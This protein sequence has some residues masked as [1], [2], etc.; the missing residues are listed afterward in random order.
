MFSTEEAQAIARAWRSFAETGTPDGEVV[1]PVIKESWKRSR[2]AGLDPFSLNKPSLTQK[3]LDRRLTRRK[4]VIEIAKPFMRLL[5]DFVAGSGFAVVLSDEEGCVLEVVADSDAV[6]NACKES[7]LVTGGVR[8]E[9]FVG[10]NGIGTCLALNEP[11]L[12]W[13]EEHFFIGLHKWTCTGVPIHGES[14]E[15][16][17]CLSMSGPKERVHLHT[18]GM[19]IAAAAAIEK[20]ISLERSTAETLHMNQLLIAATENL[21]E[22]LVGINAMGSITHINHCACDML[23]TAQERAIG[24]A[25]GEVID[26]P[27]LYCDVKSVTSEVIDREMTLKIGGKSVS[28]SVTLK[29]LQNNAGLSEGAIVIIKPTSSVHRLV[30]RVTAARAHYSFEHIV[31]VSEKMREVVRQASVAAR[32]TSTVLLMGESGTGKELLAQAIHNA[33]RR[34]GGPF[35]AINC[36]GLPR[37]LVESELFGYE[38]GS[39]TG[40]KKEG[41]PGKFELADTGTIFLD[42][43]ADMP[44]DIQGT[45]LRVLQE[46]EVVRVGGSAGKQVDVRTI[47]ATNK[48]LESAV[49]EK[50][51]RL[52]LYYRL[53]VFSIRVPPLRERRDDIAILADYFTK[54]YRSKM[55]KPVMGIEG[56]AL[57]LLREW[58]WPGNVRELENVIERALNVCESERITVQDLP[59]YLVSGETKREQPSESGEAREPWGALSTIETVQAQA[60]VE[61]LEKTGGNIRKAA[62]N[63]GL[64]RRTMYRKLR[65]YGLAPEQFRGA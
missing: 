17:G 38:G 53:N 57:S 4:N 65:R 40:S 14:G 61:A 27:Q 28:H 11:V 3:E 34:R 46:K 22:G 44:Y 62:D 48:D 30:N 42:E 15:I 43:I 33:G 20:Q 35:I 26:S 25:L 8:A 16:L 59:H 32:S 18:L 7:A 37:G 23:R 47:A 21:P 60:I 5:A 41:H 39:F 58:D 64:G 6:A 10:T 24:R 36:G 13:G 12:I 9:R 56:D 52:D 51:F 29:P 19:V 2:R 1:R 50:S 54:K 31:G 45:L 63:L 55:N 49:Q